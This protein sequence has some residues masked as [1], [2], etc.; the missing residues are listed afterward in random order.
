MPDLRVIDEL[1]EDFPESW[2]KSSSRK[3]AEHIAKFLLENNFEVN[4]FDIGK[5]FIFIKTSNDPEK[6]ARQIIAFKKIDDETEKFEKKLIEIIK[7]EFE[8]ELNKDFDELKMETSD[9]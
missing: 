3:I 7:I 4:D 8:K 9:E 2:N 5:F 6:I 1:S